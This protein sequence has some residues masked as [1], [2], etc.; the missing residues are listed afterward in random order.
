MR[1]T[2]RRV[3]REFSIIVPKRNNA[4][5]SLGAIRMAAS[6][7]GRGNEMKKPDPRR[8]F[9]RSLLALGGAGLATAQSKRPALVCDAAD[10]WSLQ[11]GE[12]AATGQSGPCV[13]LRDVREALVE[14]CRAV[15]DANTFAGVSGSRSVR[16]S[17]VGNHLARAS[18]AVGTAVGVSADALFLAANRE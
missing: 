15:A 4:T 13:V 18:K 3:D 12:F 9:M 1:G 6:Q 2:R 8:R 5:G 17:I 14:G 16:I 7:L 10:G 11:G